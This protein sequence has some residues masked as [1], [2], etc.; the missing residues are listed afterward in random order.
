MS[1]SKQARKTMKREL[2]KALKENVNKTKKQRKPSQEAE[3][4]QQIE[5]SYREER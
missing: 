4:F 3:M 5:Q 2:A 1:T